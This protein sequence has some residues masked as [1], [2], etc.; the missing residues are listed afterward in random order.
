MPVLRA[1][2]LLAITLVPSAAATFGT[3]V[4]HASALSDLVLD[5]KNNRLLVVNTEANTVEVYRTNTNPPS[6]LTSIK[7]DAEPLAIAFSPA[8]KALYVACYSASVLD[9][10]DTS[11]SA[12]SLTSV[13]LPA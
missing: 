3:V 12:F 8:R 7:T 2:A 1:L 4:T 11:T 10:I 5:E 9:I 13:H 6:L